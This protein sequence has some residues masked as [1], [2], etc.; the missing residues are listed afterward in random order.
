MSLEVNLY[1]V[2]WFRANVLLRISGP[3]VLVIENGQRGQRLVAT[4]DRRDFASALREFLPVVERP[5]R[6]RCPYADR[7]HG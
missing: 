1:N 4:I 5:K 3:N 7:P 6:E 2:A